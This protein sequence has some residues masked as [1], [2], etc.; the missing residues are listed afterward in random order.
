MPKN[1]KAKAEARAASQRGDIRY[2][3]ARRQTRP[4]A[5]P[6]PLPE[7]S[8]ENGNVAYSNEQ[9]RACALAV[10]ALV[11]GDR[12][13]RIAGYVTT[14]TEHDD[15][16]FAFSSL[17][18]GEDDLDWREV[19]GGDAAA[20]LAPFSHEVHAPRGGLG[21]PSPTAG[22]AAAGCLEADATAPVATF[23][24]RV[25]EVLATLAL[26][27]GVELVIDEDLLDQGG[28]RDAWE[29]EIFRLSR[30]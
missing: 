8:F 9:V 15:E 11:G 21:A 30:R 26:P 5:L 2:V 20:L 25:G 18:D 27:E 28:G 10:V 3:V 17:R 13:E 29:R 23:A 6:A 22:G 4:E 16:A 1:R 24:R 12:H 19:R 7:L 14:I